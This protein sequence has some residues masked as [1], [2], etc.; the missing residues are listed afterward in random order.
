MLTS[1]LAAVQ[2]GF[3]HSVQFS[4]L[5]DWGIGGDMKDDSAEIFFQYFL[6]EALGNSPGTGRDVHSLMLSIQHFLCHPRHC[7]PSM[8]PWRMVS[9]E[10]V[11]ACDM[12]EPCKF[13]SSDSCQK[14]FLWTHKK[15]DHA[16]TQSLVFVFQI[17]DAEKSP[18]ALDCKSLDPFSG[19]SKQGPYFTVIEDDGGNK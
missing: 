18:K 10:A 6:H 9:G 11:V 17:K 13:P 5:T 14:R 1:F 16:R 3:L 8:V 19:V 4:P 7:P 2:I 12:P 15:V